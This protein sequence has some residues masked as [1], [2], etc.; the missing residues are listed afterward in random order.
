MVTERVR[1]QNKGLSDK[2]INTILD[3]RK[4]VTRAIYEKVRKKFISRNKNKPIPNRG[5]IPTILDFLQD[6][7]DK[8]ISLSTLKVQVAA[9]SSIMD[10]RL[11]EDPLIKR[12]LMSL[13]KARLAKMNRTLPTLDMYTVLR[14]F[15]SPPFEPMEDG[16]DKKL[17]LKT[18]LLV[19]LVSARRVSEIQALSIMEPC[20]LIHLDKIILS[21][22][23]AFL[24]KV[25]TTFH[26]TQNISIPSLP[27]TMDSK[28]KTLTTNSM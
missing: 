7:A 17:T 27:K 9:L 3:S 6:G 4:P 16:I 8:N 5:I 21:L 19:A 23:L 25:S 15:L 11:A 24:P 12:F 18:A 13:K 1:L 22:D 10:T 26:R 28:K 14:G 2:V 20:C